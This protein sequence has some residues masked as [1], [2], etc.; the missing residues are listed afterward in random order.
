ML[1][2]NKKVIAGPADL[3]EG[4]VMMECTICKKKFAVPAE[5]A[6]KVKDDEAVVCQDCGA[7]ADKAAAATSVADMKANPP[8]EVTKALGK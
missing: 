2:Q 7:S 1:I 4:E 6:A 3:G 8:D 5:E